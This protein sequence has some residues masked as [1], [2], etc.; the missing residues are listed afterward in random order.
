M[1]GELPGEVVPLPVRLPV[2][3][4]LPISVPPEFTTTLLVMTPL[5]SKVL[6]LLTTVSLVVLV[7]WVLP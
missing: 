3:V 5:F 7:V 1:P 6:P 4:P 2:K